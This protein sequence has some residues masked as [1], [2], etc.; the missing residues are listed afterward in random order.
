[1]AAVE[2]LGVLVDA[3]SARKS[4]VTSRKLPPYEGHISSS[5]AKLTLSSVKIYKY[6]SYWMRLSIAT[7]YREQLGMDERDIV[8][9]GL[10]GQCRKVGKLQEVV[11]CPTCNPSTSVITVTEPYGET[12]A[13]T[14]PEGMEQYQ[15]TLRSNCTS[16]RDHLK[17]LL[18][19]E[20]KLG[21]HSLLSPTF[22]LRARKKPSRP[23]IK[24][25]TPP[26]DM[27]STQSDPID[28]FPIIEGF[29]LLQPLPTFSPALPTLQSVQ[30]L[31]QQLQAL[32]QQ[33]QQ[34]PHLSPRQQLTDSDMGVTE[35]PMER[36]PPPP[37]IA[38]PPPIGSYVTRAL[39][40]HLNEADWRRLFS[41]F[42]ILA[43]QICGIADLGTAFVPRFASPESPGVAVI[44]IATQQPLETPLTVQ[45]SVEQCFTLFSLY[46]ANLVPS[47]ANLYTRD[48]LTSGVVTVIPF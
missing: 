42:V 45:N 16:S 41:H 40:V 23:I 13:K 5:N 11:V 48:L 43:R 17:A 31:H 37:P 36:V 14:S 2:E 26:T 22:V 32:Q 39:R 18:L 33:I 10:A 25:N 29:S 4:S 8:A 34:A 9:A 7:H 35:K 19:M 20:V 15:F 44:T 28:S 21:P 12:C 24:R 1:M 47:Y 30:P 6:G 3:A 46:L 38:S 27:E